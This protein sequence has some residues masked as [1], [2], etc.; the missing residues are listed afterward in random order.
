[1]R[2]NQ[3]STLTVTKIVVVTLIATALCAATAQARPLAIS[4]SQDQ[5]RVSSFSLNFGEL[6]GVASALIA[7][8]D[9]TVEIDAETGSARLIEYQQEID[10]LMLPGGFSTGNIHVEI[11]EDSSSGTFDS[12]TGEFTTNE[13]Y[14]IFFDGDLSAFGL[15]SPVL[16]PSTS[17][18]TITIDSNTSS[19]SV[20]LDWEGASEL[21]NPFD[22][23]TPLSFTYIC[24]MSTAFVPEADT[25]LEVSLIPFTQNL[26]LPRWLETNLLASLN[27]SSYL[28][29]IGRD[30]AAERNLIAFINKV[31][32]LADRRIDADDADIMI[33]VA[34]AT[35]FLLDTTKPGRRGR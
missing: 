22:P 28:I 33:D 12:R 17:T 30:N 5:A 6:G 4:A 21:S 9:L 31:D 15:E 2:M 19:G 11:V 1:M 23:A 13:L 20:Q 35:I 18:G 8:T 3:Q 14:A 25:M 24:T 29:D 26:A 10:P 34:E 27:R 32:A 16:L 7:Q